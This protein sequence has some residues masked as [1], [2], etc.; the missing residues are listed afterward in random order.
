MMTVVGTA[1][2]TW[3]KTTH[4][5]ITPYPEVSWSEWYLTEILVSVD[6]TTHHIEI[7]S[8]EPQVLDYGS[9]THKTYSTCDAYGAYGTDRNYKTIF[10]TMYFF[11]TGEFQIEV[12]YNDVAYKYQLKPY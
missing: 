4:Y 2:T 8:S 11:F 6:P 12:Q 5:S 10:V 1:Q 7:Y 3:Y 9:L